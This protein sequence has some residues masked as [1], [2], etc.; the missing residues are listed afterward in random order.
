MIADTDSVDLPS[1]VLLREGR[2][3]D[4]V[5]GDSWAL[6]GSGAF[7]LGRVGCPLGMIVRELSDAFELPLEAARLDVLRFAWALNTLALV[8]IVQRGPRIRRLADWVALALRLAPAGAFPIPLARRH[9]L[10]T[11]SVPRAL[12]SALTAA[13]PRIAIVALLATAV[14]LQLA[15]VAG[16][17]GSVFLLA[18]ALGAGTGIGL[19]LHEAGH[20]ASLRG[21][22]SALV[23]RGRRTFV[24]H[25]PVGE[26]RRALVAL[27]GPGVVVM[28]GLAFVVSG[29]AIG[30]PGLVIL[31]LPLTAHALSLTMIGGDGRVACGI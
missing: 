9:S 28:V 19:G 16:A 31:G 3:E 25:A 23:L 2:L 5:R 20:V 30:T 27:C 14:A 24:L 26:R 8:N 4:I 15:A 29:V 1:G 10:D 17:T 21:V 18:M 11:R 22:P 6:N 12:A 13:G 7:V